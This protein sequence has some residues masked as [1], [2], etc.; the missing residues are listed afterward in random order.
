MPCTG[1]STPSGSA[2]VLSTGTDDAVATPSDA[3]EAPSTEGSV[4]SRSTSKRCCRIRP[5]PPATAA[6]EPTVTA[7]STNC[8]R[9]G[10]IVTDR[11]RDPPE[12]CE[13]SEAPDPPGAAASAA[14]RRGDNHHSTANETT[15][16]TIV[17]SSLPR[18]GAGRSSTAQAPRTPT[19]TV[20]IDARKRSP[21]TASTPTIAPMPRT[22]TRA[23]V[24]STTLSFVPNCSMAQSFNHFGVTSMNSWPTG[25]T[26]DEDPRTSPTTSSAAAS[27]APVA[28]RP[29]TRPRQIDG[30]CVDRVPCRSPSPSPS[31]SS[32][33]ASTVPAP[34][35]IADPSAGSTVSRS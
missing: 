13:P 27:P 6:T 23:P 8:R 24:T 29:R 32:V 19:P 31:P 21:R 7:P 22:T 3:S 16:P 20:R 17:G 14:T 11:G 9:S 2:V 10:P 18:S 28:R 1:R 15:V 26:G 12:T 30:R 4:K 35:G 5:T 33:S 34:T 25:T